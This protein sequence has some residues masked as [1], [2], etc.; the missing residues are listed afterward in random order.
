MITKE[1]L[2]E[3][4]FDYIPQYGKF[5]FY[6]AKEVYILCFISA[7]EFWLETEYA[8]TKLAIESSNDLQTLIKI[9]S[10]GK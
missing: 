4:G 3:L 6:I 7:N 10:N 5:Q 1:Q 8:S 9:L 2:L